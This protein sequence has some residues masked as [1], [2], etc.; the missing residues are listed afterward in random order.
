MPLAISL[1]LPLCC[2]DAVGYLGATKSRKAFYR[3]V[4]TLA[5]LA[6]LKLLWDGGC[7]DLMRWGR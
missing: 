6:S 5:V 3:V 1:W 2:R 4:Y 7:P